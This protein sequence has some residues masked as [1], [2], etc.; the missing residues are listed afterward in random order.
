MY[1]GIIFIK[2]KR[3]NTDSV[4]KVNESKNNYPEWKKP[5]KNAYFMISL[6]KNRIIE[7]IN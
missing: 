7:N 2:S 5:E 4:N 1:S 3:L 6:T